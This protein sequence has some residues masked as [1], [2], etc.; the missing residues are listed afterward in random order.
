MYLS[1]FAADTDTVTAAGAPGVVY[2]GTV[3]GAHNRG[4]RNITCAN[5]VPGVG[6][7]ANVVPG[8][9][10]LVGTALGDDSISKRRLRHRNGQVLTLDANGVIWTAGNYIT[11]IENYEFW[12]V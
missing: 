1:I 9:T 7:I 6:N 3:S 10:V 11:V 8:Q 12:P 4:A 5:L 2:A